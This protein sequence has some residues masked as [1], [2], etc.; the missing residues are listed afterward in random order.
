MDPQEDIPIQAPYSLSAMSCVDDN[1]DTSHDNSDRK[2][3]T[4]SRSLSELNARDAGG[5]GTRTRRNEDGPEHNLGH[6]S[7]KMTSNDTN[8]AP[9]KY[10]GD[11]SGNDH[12][13][14]PSSELQDP[15]MS[16]GAPQEYQTSGGPGPA[17]T[18]NPNHEPPQH[19]P[20]YQLPVQ[21]SSDPQHH[22]YWDNRTHQWQ[23]YN[24]CSAPL[25]NQ[26]APSEYHSYHHYY[27]S[28]PQPSSYHYSPHI[29]NLSATKNE[30][31]QQYRGE[32]NG[33]SSCDENSHPNI[34]DTKTPGRQ[35]SSHLIPAS[36]PL[37]NDEN[38]RPAKR[39]RVDSAISTHDANCNASDADET[40]DHH[41]HESGNFSIRINNNVRGDHVHSS[42]T[43]KEASASASQYEYPYP[44]STSSS[45]VVG[46][47]PL[48]PINPN[49]PYE[50]STP[51]RH[52]NTSNGTGV[53]RQQQQGYPPYNFYDSIA[54]TIEPA[55]ISA[56]NTDD[57]GHAYYHP[58]PPQHHP[59][60]S[61][62]NNSSSSPY[63]YPPPTYNLNSDIQHNS[64]FG[65]DDHRDR[66][67][68]SCFPDGAN[69]AGVGV[70]DEA[71]KIFVTPE[72]SNIEGDGAD[73]ITSSHSGRENE[74]V[75]RPVTYTPGQ[76]QSRHVSTVSSQSSRSSSKPRQNQSSHS[77]GGIYSTTTR[78]PSAC[79][80]R[81]Q[82]QS[83]AW[84]ERFEELKEYKSIH[85]N[86]LVPQKYP[87]N[88]R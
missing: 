39:S 76:T 70:E 73:C 75:A 58:P 35:G 8:D 28:Q 62:P 3:R 9:G 52:S 36:T 53:G 1:I 82:L 42:S 66:N 18:T 41:D 74:V 57:L 49:T 10:E 88:P 50:Y 25:D 67:G 72:H 47:H 22:P 54:S 61:Y 13:R 79:S 56:S 34:S 78:Q 31:S 23:Y 65:R 44:P 29:F 20:A 16:P 38:T 21:Y 64:T 85:G 87:Q 51:W 19:H 59:Y 37:T 5:T 24:P 55:P 86:C 63:E 14:A 80:D 33:P 12:H 32:R 81:K 46:T 69:S 48:R 7:L 71:H 15:V 27:H 30:R 77:G 68:N 11:G 43:S 4:R 45:G 84:F 40:S 6:F 60:A 2:S 83:Q 26:Y 17:Y